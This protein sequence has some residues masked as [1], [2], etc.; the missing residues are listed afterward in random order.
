MKIAVVLFS[1]HGVAQA[2]ACLDA[3]AAS[4]PPERLD[5]VY[6]VLSG[7]AADDLA[8]DGA[9]LH[10]PATDGT[11]EPLVEAGVKATEAAIADRAAD[12]VLVL[13]D[14][15][16][17]RPGWL[18]EVEAS[19]AAHPDAAILAPHLVGVSAAV[20]GAGADAPALS[21]SIDEGAAVCLALVTDALLAGR[22]QP[23]VE[24][25]GMSVDIDIEPAPVAEPEP[26][27]R[28]RPF[29]S[30]PLERRS[31]FAARPHPYYIV[32]PDFRESSAGIW[33]L[34]ALCHALNS[35]GH[36]AY[37]VAAGETNPDWITPVVDAR[38]S[39]RH[40]AAGLSPIAVYPEI[41]AGNPLEAKVVARYILNVPGFFTG[42]GMQEQPGDLLYYYSEQFIGD[43]DPAGLDFL[44]LPTVDP[45][46]FRPDPDR[47]RDRVLVYQNR[48]PRERI[49]LDEFPPG[50]ELLTLDD[51][52]PLPELAELFKSTR[53]LY[54]FELSGTCDMAMA[55]G[56][57]VIYRA[58]GLLKEL[59]STFRYGTAGAAMSDEPG[60]LE[61][62]TA[63]V[64]EVA[65]AIARREDIF[66][67]ELEAFVAATQAAADG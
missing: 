6:V 58:D 15:M 22:S 61:R 14:D 5:D 40:A 36:E 50:A 3:L 43:Q 53:V 57:P 10:D 27:T 64:G 18:P 31:I 17:L 30:A 7:A 65:D 66:W 54:S 19:L 34:H 24:V 28:P 21:A 59:P 38:I 35:A 56:C 45:A 2:N 42:E 9:D 49:D 11:F 12:V 41:V 62:A 55:A 39:E 32:A 23:L 1:V 16:R 60:G 44:T 63:T 51:P 48:F 33:V 47:P 37:L 8:D 4:A 20:V 29:A 46:L 13:S 52:L 67:Q 26:V 25:P